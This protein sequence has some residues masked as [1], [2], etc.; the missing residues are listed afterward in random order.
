MS[1]VFN[2]NHNATW[3][4]QSQLAF[5]MPMFNISTLL[6]FKISTAES[7]QHMC[8][9]HNWRCSSFFSQIALFLFLLFHMS[10]NEKATD[11]SCVLYTS[12]CLM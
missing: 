10:V 8:E 3:K 6:Y 11:K 1:P 5:I 12:N 9:S 7:I 4:F 2:S